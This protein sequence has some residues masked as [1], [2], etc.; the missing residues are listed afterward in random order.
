MVRL[1]GWQHACSVLDIHLHRFKHNF[2]KFHI[3]HT[4]SQESLRQQELQIG[5]L[6][7]IV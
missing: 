6:H 5:L 7:S 4:F 1:I 3:F 2:T